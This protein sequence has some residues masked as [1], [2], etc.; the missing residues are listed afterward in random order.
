MA[1]KLSPL[2]A[3]PKQRRRFV[4]R[5]PTLDPADRRAVRNV[6]VYSVVALL[7]CLALTAAIVVVCLWVRLALWIV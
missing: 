4:P 7:A 2:W 6:A 3:A 5:L 1:A